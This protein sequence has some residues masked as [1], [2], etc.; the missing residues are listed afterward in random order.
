MNLRTRR[1]SRALLGT[2]GFAVTVAGAGAVAARMRWH[3]AIDRLVVVSP[4]RANRR[5]SPSLIIV[6]DLEPARFR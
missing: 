5:S 6:L 3:P 2:L 1:V 4:E